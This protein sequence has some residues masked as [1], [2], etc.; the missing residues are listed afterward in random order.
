MVWSLLVCG[1]HRPACH[2]EAFRV[3]LAR[4]PS[5][6]IGGEIDDGL[7]GSTAGRGSPVIR[8]LVETTKAIQLLGTTEHLNG[9]RGNSSP[10]RRER[11]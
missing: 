1:Y 2:I 5:R 10:T 11:E 3:N 6:W 7:T 8:D 4:P 9:G